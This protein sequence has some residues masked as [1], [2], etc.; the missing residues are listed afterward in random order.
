LSDTCVGTGLFSSNADW[1]GIDLYETG[2]CSMHID[3][4][5]ED[6]RIIMDMAEYSYEKK[7]KTNIFGIFNYCLKE[8]ENYLSRMKGIL[9]SAIVRVITFSLVCYRITLNGIK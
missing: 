1:D 2:S 6:S 8:G 5:S 4:P 3:V 9:V 7:C